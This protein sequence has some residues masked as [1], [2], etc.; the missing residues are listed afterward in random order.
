M[1]TNYQYQGLLFLCHDMLLLFED[2]L[3]E[4]SRWMMKLF[5]TQETHSDLRRTRILDDNV[6]KRGIVFPLK[7]I[8]KRKKHF[9]GFNLDLIFRNSSRDNLKVVNSLYWKHFW[10]IEYLTAWG[11]S[12][13]LEQLR[14]LSSR[15]R[16]AS[17]VSNTSSTGLPENSGGRSERNYKIYICLSDLK[18]MGHYM[19]LLD[20][21][22]L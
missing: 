9:T 22:W 20:K 14:F 1:T 15:K 17:T 4:L 8:G 3:L 13:W 18:V 19:F 12:G 5:L 2:R 11:I 7:T 10:Q 16:R 6:V 21:I